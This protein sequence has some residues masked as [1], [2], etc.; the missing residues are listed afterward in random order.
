[1]TAMK[2]PNDFIRILL[3]WRNDMRVCGAPEGRL[4]SVGEA[5]DIEYGHKSAAVFSFK[6]TRN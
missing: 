4:I 2:I 5:P 3:E 1:M 6:V